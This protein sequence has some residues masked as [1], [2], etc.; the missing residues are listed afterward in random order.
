MRISV[1][2]SANEK[3]NPLFF[4]K[5]TQLGHW[6]GSNGHT[7]VYGGCDMG[8]MECVA[9][10]VHETGGHVV[11][12]V[13]SILEKGGHAST[14]IDELVRCETLDERK[15]LMLLNSDVAVA[16]PGGIGTL[17]EVFS[18]ASQATL[19][20]HHQHVLVYDMCHFWQPL[21]ALLDH[22]QGQG[23]MRGDYHRLISFFHSVEELETH[24]IHIGTNNLS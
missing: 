13:P 22:L 3:I 12:V 8:L 1:F 10:A 24:L 11:G 5:T 2:C 9:K 18:M 17:D 6:I 15:R 23:L 20:Y 19:G 21:E 14:F 7:L 4:E 16:L